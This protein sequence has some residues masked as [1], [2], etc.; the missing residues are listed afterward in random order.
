MEEFKPIEFQRTRDFSRK[1][2]A[3]FEFVRQN[4]KPLGKAIL[5]IAGPSVLVGS[6]LIGSFMG[7]FFKLTFGLQSNGG[8]PEALGQYFLSP[9][10]W[11]QLLLMFV[12]LFVSLIVT[13]ATINCYLVLYH[14]KK[15][16]QIEVSEVWDRVRAAFWGYVGTTVL[17][18]LAFMLVYILL[19]IPAVMLGAISPFLVFLGVLIFIAG[20]FYV[21]ISSSLTYFIQLYEKRNFFDALA[22]SFRLV[23]NGKWWS[24]FGLLMILQLIVG[25]SSYIF[26][27][28]YYVILFT[29]T[30]HSVS[31]DNPF[32]FSDTMR[33]VVIACFTLYYL[34]Q[35]LLYALPNVGIAFQYFNLVE[36]K[37]AKGLMG[38]IQ[39]LGQVKPDDGRPPEQF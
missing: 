27:I 13:I 15:T 12:L 38:E 29:S 2:N 33:I 14:E 6:L 22:R 20:L 30:M 26:L 35:L 37:E 25:I 10:F 19:L 4:Y 7:D 34:A 9:S 24:T 28:P 3:T 39:M 21:F 32:E 16:N 11:L 23:N 36:L 8:D 17:F 18:F 1:L 31:T 5:M